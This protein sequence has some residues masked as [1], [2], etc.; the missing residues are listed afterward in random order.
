MQ[1]I[2]A[3]AMLSAFSAGAIFAHPG[4]LPV[5]PEVSFSSAASSATESATT[6][7]VQVVLSQAATAPVSIPFTVGGSATSADAT[8]TAGPLVIPVGQSTGTIAVTVLQDSLSEG[9]ERVALTLGTPTNGTLG[10]TT[11]H[12][13]VI[14]DDEPAA[15]LSFTQASSSRGE[16]AGTAAISLTLS[17]PRTEEA[18]VSFSQTGTATPGGVDV[19]TSPMS[20]II[21]PAGATTATLNANLV[22]DLIDEPNE[23][24]IV[25]LLAPVNCAL[26]TIAQHTLT[27]TDDDAPPTVAFA[28][29]SSFLVE[30]ASGTMA[31]VTLSAP[32]S[33]DVTVP[34]AATGTATVG[35]DY[36]WTPGGM[37]ASGALMIPAGA[38]SANVVLSTILDSTVEG[39]ETAIF[40]LG[41][42]TNGTLGAGTSHQVRLIDDDGPL[43]QVAF[44]SSGGSVP[45]SIGSLQVSVVATDYAAQPV[46]VPITTGGTATLGTDY[47]LGTST[48]TI[49]VGSLSATATVTVVD[50]AAQESLETIVLGMGA[51]TGASV[52]STAQHTISVMD[53]DG[54]PTLTFAAPTSS[55]AEGAGMKLVDVV[56]SGPAPAP[57]TVPVTLSGTAMGGGMDFSV[58]PNPLVIPAGASTGQFVVNLVG[59]TLY[60]NNETVGLTFGALAGADPGGIVQHTLTITNDDP[61]P[62]VAFTSFRNVVAEMDGSFSVRLALSAVSGLPVQVP[63]TVSGTGSGPSDCTLPPSPAMIPAGAAFVDLPVTLVVDRIPELG[64]KILFELGAAPSNATLGTTLSHLVLLKDGDRGAL[65]VPSALTPSVFSLSF[66]T[67]RTTQASVS[68]SVFFTNVHTTPLTLVDVARVGPMKG[69]FGLSF[70]VALPITLAPGASARVDVTFQPVGRGE[71]TLV[72]SPV[73]QQTTSAPSTVALSGIA[74]GGTGEEI[75]MNAADVLFDGPARQDYSPEYGAT[76]GAL[77]ENS[78]EV[79]GTTLDALYQTFRAGQLFSYAIELPNGAYDVKIHSW[80]PVQAQVGAR[81]MDVYMEGAEVIDDLDLFAEVGPATAY[82]SSPQRVTVS[83]GVLDLTFEGEVGQAIVSA[84]E[85]RS[86]PVLGTSTT[87]LS[88]GDVE[89]GASST[90]TV[91]FQNTGLHGGVLNRLTFRVSSIGDARDFSVE[92]GGVVYTG[93][94]ETIVRTPQILLP[95]G[96]TSIPVTFTPTYH[97]DHFVTLEFE[98]SVTGALF[99]VDLTG[100]GGA[101]AGW[102]FLHPVP[103]N[104]PVFVVDYDN[105]GFESVTL[106]GSESHTHE[107]G[108]SLTAFEWQIGG[109]PVATTVDTVQIL[110]IGSTTVGLTIGDD[111]V[112]AATASDVRTIT[113]HP[114]DQVP[115]VLALYYD[116]ASLGEVFLLDNVPARYDFAARLASLQIDATGGKVGTSPFDQKVMVQWLTHFETTSAR[117]LGFQATGGVQRR[118]FVDGGPVTGP[119]TLAAGVHKLDLRFAVSSLSDVPLQLT[120][121]E[122]GSV[123]TDIQN[124]LAYDLGP[125]PPAI[126]AMPTSGTDL[127]GNRI[128]IKGFGFFPE[129]QTIVHWGST[130]ITS[131]Q[132]DEWNGEQI[133]LTT[134]PGSGSIMVTVET[135]QGISDPV[136]F[137]YSPTGPIPVRFTL[138]NGQAVS[139]ANVTCAQWG[140]DGKLYVG[141][142][143]GSLRV[144]TYDENW[145]VTSIQYRVGVS[146]LTNRDTLGMAFN[147]FDVYNPQDPTSL[148]LYISHGEQFQNG[149]GAFTGPS[150]FTGQ[151]SVLTGPYFDNPQPLITQLPVSNHDHS[152]NGPFFDDNGDLLLC[153]GGNTNA[154]VTDPHLGDI[155]ESPFSGAVLRAFTSRPNFNGA[156]L[157]QDSATGV[158]VDDQVY[159]ELTDIAPGVD[160]EVYAPGFRN[161]LD[162][163]LHTNGYLYSTDNGANAGFGPASL[164]MT[165]QGGVSSANSPDEIN[166][167]EPGIYYGSANRSRGSFDPRQA[168]FRDAWQP[169]V[170]NTFRAPISVVNSSTNGIEEYRAT[171]FNSAMRGN[172]VASKWNAGL[173]RIIL[174]ADG[175][176]VSTQTLHDSNANTAFPPNRGLDV[177][178]GP[179]GALISIDYTSGK[180]RV[181]VPDDVAAIGP[182]PYDIFPWRVTAGGGQRFVIGGKNFGTNLANVSVTIGGVP[183]TLTSVNNGRIVGTFPPSPTGEATELLDVTVTI[184]GSPRTITQAMRYL[185]ASPGLKKGTW[186]NGSVLPLPLGEVASAI[187]GQKLY[188][189]G[190]G[191]SS[192]F[193]HD[194]YQGSWSMGLAQRQFPGNH[195]GIEVIGTKIYL[196][197]GLDSGSAGRVQIYDTVANAWS[198]G[199][200]MPWNGGSCATAVIDGK[201]YVGGG[202]L[203]GSGTAGNF[204]VY[205]PTLDTWT[206][207][208][209]VPT[210]V[211]HAASGTD[212]EKLYVFGGRQGMNVP[213]AGF[214]DVQIYDP[215]SNTWETSDA[216]QAAPMPLGRGGTG[217]AV[218]YGGEFYIMGG[219]DASQAFSDVQVYNPT[220]DSWRMDKPMPTARHGIYPTL[221]ESRI[222]VLGGGLV[223]GFGFSTVSEVYSPR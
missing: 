90:L 179:G 112:P 175:R 34:V 190:Q 91:D 66:P 27:I 194:L 101:Q 165:T 24:F 22:Q 67:T 82:V 97:E 149:G 176:R 14:V 28:A 74:F 171:A 49:P 99:E 207:L 1:S 94:T 45:E 19:S 155:P 213:Q 117:T 54:V 46:V 10:A 89:Q 96:T 184:N 38:T 76:G 13:V 180:I 100:T 122:S 174:S 95:P 120:I 62:T 72:L 9:R 78:S 172:L 4:S 8:V 20:P 156:I 151:V 189:L 105:D 135:P 134:P 125:I 144:L 219:E 177:I 56:L 41:A 195:H 64:E 197:G 88:F 48:V 127:G 143:D 210:P 128:E 102:G 145:T 106:L 158:Y 157:Y 71:R 83:D 58:T 218:F 108:H 181:Q 167:V 141:V 5:D 220:T 80:E 140:P 216:G 86:V 169:S 104:D 7:N 142:L 173:Y 103:D 201:I 65:A 153:V 124:A 191:N 202:N 75:L 222:F 32:S 116:G 21:V 70:P 30:S 60:E 59:D 118:V 3:A 183:A 185:P 111:N 164:S 93:S 61:Q 119:V 163:V 170:A 160:I 199:T 33:F 68:Q 36:T 113:V 138:L 203:Q 212:G 12:E 152:V 92:V 35:S 192:T 121:M 11:A 31:S 147:P 85:V 217:H 50:D 110:P 209:M 211:N 26:G 69:D 73:T 193:V 215:V 2:F 114:V 47:T 25:T 51:V 53:N 205:D 37:S 200:P 133:T 168:V 18:R 79:S 208:G 150:Y 57:V 186:H 77:G 161:S 221:F 126:H 87:S 137:D 132:F 159:G 223:S 130:D 162:L 6:V 178:A 214:D 146:G 63:F 81:V 40:T 17:T 131:A 107:P 196:M 129:A 15:T 39:T 187:V 154:G 198:L 139:I 42:P 123:A 109:V 204:A 148:K 98:N 44:A 166:L 43:V 182:T 52:G 55:A 188:V 84:I 206:P 16:G 23:T 115:G 136:Q 29:P